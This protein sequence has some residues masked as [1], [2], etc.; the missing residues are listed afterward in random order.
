MVGRIEF[1]E[2]TEFLM[3][4]HEPE[5]LKYFTLRRLRPLTQLASNG[6]KIKNFDE[7]MATIRLG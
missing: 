3:D 5:S 1:I 6:D 7:M 4:T 2:I